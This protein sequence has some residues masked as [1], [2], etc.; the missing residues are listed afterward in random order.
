MFEA[1]AVSTGAVALGEIGDKTQLLALMLAA[2]YRKPAA[3]LA[4]IAVATVANHALAGALGAW[5]A[6]LMS[7]SSLRWALGLGFIAMAAWL[8]VPDRDDG[9]D[10]GPRRG[11]PFGAFGITLV[12]FFLA[13]MGDKT[14]LA[15]VG[16]AARFPAEW[17]AVIAGS[18]LGLL[19]ANAPV[20]LW[21]GKLLERIPMQAVRW[22]AA[23][24]FAVLGVA[25]LIV[26]RIAG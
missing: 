23:T 22:L 18:T 6:S 24:L 14:Q 13:E 20:V 19:L 4:G 8:L 5:V 12:A 16:L 9:L 7:P 17:G 10:A 25:V 1:M 11:L 21:G 26:G 2:R 3:I 15:T